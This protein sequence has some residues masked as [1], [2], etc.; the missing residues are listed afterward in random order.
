MYDVDYTGQQYA[1][2]HLLLLSKGPAYFPIK[3]WENKV[4]KQRLS[5]QNKDKNDFFFTHPLSFSY[6]QN[7]KHL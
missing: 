3:S 7:V 6:N 2:V 1:I 5:G 4:R